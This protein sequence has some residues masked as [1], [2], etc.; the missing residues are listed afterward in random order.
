LELEDNKQNEEAYLTIKLTQCLHINMFMFFFI[1]NQ[2]RAGM[3]R[4]G[5]Q[6][7]GKDSEEEEAAM[8]AHEISPQQA[9][10]DI[11]VEFVDRSAQGV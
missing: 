6:S 7:S 8:R 5:R 2:R 1:G 10:T 9:F 3:R 4:R 11:D